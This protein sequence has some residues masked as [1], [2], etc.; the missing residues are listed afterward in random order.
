MGVTRTIWFE[1]SVD[2]FRTFQ[3]ALEK[4]GVR[5]ELPFWVRDREQQAQ[6]SRIASSSSGIGNQQLAHLEV[7][8]HEAQRLLRIRQEDE[9]QELQQRHERE[10]Q[11]L[12]QSY[13]RRRQQLKADNDIA[14]EQIQAQASLALI[15][16][17][18]NQVIVSLVSTGA[19]SAITRAAK[20]FGNRRQRRKGEVVGE[21]G[22][23]PDVSEHSS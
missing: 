11:E 8:E 16:A 12:G 5:V 6:L 23:R 1:G 10:Q 19:A 3:S 17:D 20:K 22:D 4:E 7:E 14:H 21:K 2:E 18:V 15:L 9:R 13:T